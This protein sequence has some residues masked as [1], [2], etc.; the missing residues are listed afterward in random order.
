MFEPKTG[1]CFNCGADSSFPCNWKNDWFICDDCL[2]K[3]MTHFLRKVPD[4]MILKSSKK[5]RYTSVWDPF[6]KMPL[7]VIKGTLDFV[8]ENEKLIDSFNP[9]KILCDNNFELDENQGLFRVVMTTGEYSPI[10]KL[11]DI[12]DYYIQNIYE[13]DFDIF[14]DRLSSRNS[15]CGT[16]LSIELNNPYVPF[17]EFA[18][19][20]EDHIKSGFK[21]DQKKM[22]KYADEQ[23][24]GIIGK[25]SSDPKN[26]MNSYFSAINFTQQNPYSNYS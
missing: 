26:M 15:F 11:S 22:R 20:P 16:I 25:P 17:V 13:E 2:N 7:D 4:G 14:R 21:S 5:I 8:N 12:T 6:K 9:T 10:F 18:F 23:L 19:L 3:I 1:E 24:A